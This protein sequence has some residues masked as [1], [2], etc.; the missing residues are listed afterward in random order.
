MGLLCL[1]DDGNSILFACDGRA[2]VLIHSSD[3][4]LPGRIPLLEL[5]YG[6]LD[7]RSLVNLSLAPVYFE[8]LSFVLDHVLEE[9]LRP[10][11][12]VEVVDLLGGAAEILGNI[13]P[14]AFPVTEVR[15]L[16][17]IE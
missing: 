6:G 13:C 11:V 14:D 15:V 3:V 5:V 10:G 17:C 1:L 2:D 4:E 8:N 12:V 9:L 16:C 7:S